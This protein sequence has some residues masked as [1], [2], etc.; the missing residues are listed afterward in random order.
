MNTKIC[1][2]CG[3]S[4]HIHQHHI[5]PKSLGGTKTIPLCIVCHGKVHQKDFVKFNN[6]AKEG[7]KRYVENGGKLGRKDGAIED[8]N[9]WFNKPKVKPVIKL[10]KDPKLTIREIASLAG[11][12]TKLV[13]KAKRYMVKNNII[14]VNASGKIIPKKTNQFF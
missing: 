2:E 1:F 11:I 7:I 9:E 3:S 13:M 6:L 10:L 14:E 4:E 12:S 8:P 5:I